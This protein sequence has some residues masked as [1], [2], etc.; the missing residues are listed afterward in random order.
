[1][2]APTKGN[3]ELT[4][5]EKIAQRKAEIAAAQSAAAT[6]GPAQ[7]AGRVNHIQIEGIVHAPD[8]H[9]TNQGKGVLGGRLE[10]SQG[11][12]KGGAW[13]QPMVFWLEMWQNE[14]END[15]EFAEALDI[16]DKVRVV[17]EGKIKMEVYNDKN[18]IQQRAWKIALTRLTAVNGQ[19]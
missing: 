7:K 18:G 10:V 1:M 5:Q 4:P 9:F 6:E 19:K 12:D 15:T 13:K 14:G 2:A 16:V 11:T 17:A 3:P 8:F